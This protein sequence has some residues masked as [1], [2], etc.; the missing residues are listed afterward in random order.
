[1]LLEVSDI[2]SQ[3]PLEHKSAQ[4]HWQ[5]VQK[6]QSTDLPT[7]KSTDIDYN[8]TPDGDIRCFGTGALYDRDY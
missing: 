4:W 1:M 2:I 3:S 6:D 5:N 7:K 8:V